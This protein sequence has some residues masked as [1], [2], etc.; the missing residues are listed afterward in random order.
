M[1]DKKA[2][3]IVFRPFSWN[4]FEKHAALVQRQFGTDADPGQI[5]PTP[6][7]AKKM[8]Q[9]NRRCV[10]YADFPNGKP[11]GSAFAFPTTSELIGQFDRKEITE[12]ELFERTPIQSDYE[13]IYACSVMVIRPMRR[14]GIGKTLMTRVLTEL[15]NDYPE[16][17]V[18][19]W[20]TTKEGEALAKNMK[21]DQGLAKD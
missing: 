1:T 15:S 21:A 19:Y 12:R 7:F 14:K 16:A 20:A 10:F 11:V 5:P 6:E 9:L 18:F 2:L 8:L 3:Q 4:E 17:D 13:A